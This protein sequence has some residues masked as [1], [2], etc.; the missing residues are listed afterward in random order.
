M[1][2]EKRIILPVDQNNIVFPKDLIPANV[3]QFVCDVQADG[4]LVLTPLD[5]VLRSSVEP[6]LLDDTSESPEGLPNVIDFRKAKRRHQSADLKK[7]RM[8]SEV[9]QN[10]PSNEPLNFIKLHL[11]SS[12][13]EA[14]MVGEILKQAEIPYLIQSED[15][16]IFGPGASPVPGGVRMVVREADLEYAKALLAGII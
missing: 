7:K 4:R 8:A 11:F 15:I 14:E 9:K 1:S 13:I 5:G 2:S 16:G 12:R 10:V 3:E 6:L